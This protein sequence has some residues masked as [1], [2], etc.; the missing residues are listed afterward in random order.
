MGLALLLSLLA[1]LP[2]LHLLHLQLQGQP[3]Q[4]LQCLSL[5]LLE[6]SPTVGMLWEQQ[7]QQVLQEQE[8]VAGPLL[9][10]TFTLTQSLQFH[11]D[12][13]CAPWGQLPS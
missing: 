3:W 8:Q 12:R 2:L 9:A 6:P 4:P 11:W 5:V 13:L 10:F 1:A 7:A